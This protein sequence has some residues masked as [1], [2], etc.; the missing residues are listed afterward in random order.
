MIFLLLRFREFFGDGDQ[1]EGPSGTQSVLLACVAIGYLL[2]GKIK[3]DRKQEP[4]VGRLWIRVQLLGSG[5]IRLD[6]QCASPL[7]PHSPPLLVRT[8]TRSLQALIHVSVSRQR[9]RT[10]LLI[11]VTSWG[12]R[13]TRW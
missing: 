2:C 5:P 12:A 8:C 9:P 1:R 10:L 7:Y 6:W 13:I 3:A 11:P 4:S